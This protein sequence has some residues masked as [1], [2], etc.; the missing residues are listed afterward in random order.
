MNDGA[1]TLVDSLEDADIINGGAGTDTLNATLS[2]SA[3]TAVAAAISNVEII[4][5]RNITADVTVDFADVSG[6]EQIW[7]SASSA[8][9]TLTYDNAPIAAT[10]GVKNTL[11]ATDINTF[12]DVTGAADELKLAVSGAGSSTVDAVVTSTGDLAN[13]EAMSIAATGANFVDVSTF[14]AI[15]TLTVTGAGSLT[16]VVD[17]TALETVDASENTGGVTIDLTGS[18]VDLTVTGG[19]GDDTFTIDE[20]NITAA[21]DVFDGGDGTDTLAISVADLGELD[22]DAQTNFEILSISAAAIA[23]PETFDNDGL[24]YETLVIAE[25]L[26]AAGDLTIDNFNGGTVEVQASQVNDIVV[27]SVGT[28]D[29]INVVVNADAA[30]TLARLD[31]TDVETVNVSTTAA[32]DD[33]TFTAIETDGAK[34]ISFSGAG[35]VILTD[36]TDADATNNATVK[37]T[38]VDLTGQTGGF[39]MT[40]NSLGYGTTFTLG[41]LGETATATYDFDGDATDDDASELIVTA[42]FRDTI[43]FTS[44]FDGNVAIADGEFGGDVTDDRIDL[45]FF[46]ITIDDLIFTDNTDGLLITS[47]AFDGQILL[48]GVNGADVNNADFVF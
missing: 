10:F 22:A 6:V 36:I 34:A 38:N 7:N 3:G 17:V 28:S 27:A 42:G 15:E 18:A 29:S 40:A 30:V 5:I 32:T 24:G 45:S 19:A 44:A 25:D 2:D 21:D 41:N 16:A 35:D 14:N 48:V 1:G 26:A 46:D 11:S 37:I 8:A 43:K 47:D 33:V 9:R 39:E 13:I 23:G 31:V 12:D 4:N 20:G